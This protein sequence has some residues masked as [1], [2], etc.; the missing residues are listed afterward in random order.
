MTPMLF[1]MNTHILKQ[2]LQSSNYDIQSE[3]YIKPFYIV[4]IKMYNHN[5]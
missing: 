1:P 3:A 5:Y 4:G 2:I